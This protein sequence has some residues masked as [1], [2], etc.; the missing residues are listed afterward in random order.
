MGKSAQ[1]IDGKGVAGPHCK[2]RVRK[3]MKT[4]GMNE[5]EPAADSSTFASKKG[6]RRMTWDLGAVWRSWQG[7]PSFPRSPGQAA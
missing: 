6:K 4:Q 1:V 7:L 5:A 3:Y 2:Q